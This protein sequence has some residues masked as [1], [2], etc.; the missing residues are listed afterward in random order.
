M[1]SAEEV[2]DRLKSKAK[3][4]N[5]EGMAKYGMSVEQRLGVS[6]PDMRKI[7]KEL[8]RDHKL[9]LELW[10]AGIAEAKIIRTLTNTLITTI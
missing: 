1:P 10:Q 6:V 7:A 3:P 5:L 9:A 2:V 8:G 4:V